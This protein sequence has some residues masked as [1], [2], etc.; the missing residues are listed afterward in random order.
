MSDQ[1]AF[2]H[3]LATLHDAML[4]DSC[5]P[6]VS[7]LID[8]ACGIKGNDL[9]V[10]EGP[11]D[12]CRVLFVGMYR[13]GQRHE[14][15]EREYLE[16]YHSIDE[17]VPRFRQ[18]P[19]GLLVPA[20]DLFTAEELKTSPTYNEA[21]PRGGCQHAL[22]VRLE[23]LDGSHI[24][25][26]L[27]DPVDSH[28]WRSSRIAMVTAFL[29]HVRQFV[30]VRQALVG[31]EARNTTVTAL[32]DNP[33]IGVVQL[34]R[35]GR[36]MAVNDRAG[37]ILRRGDGLADRNGMLRARAADEQVRLERLVGDALPAPG[38]V[39]VSGSMLVRRSAVLPPFVVHVKPV[40]VPQPDYG[41]RHVAALVLI[42]EP[43]HHQRVDP[44]LV[45]TTLGLTPGESQVAVWL[46]EG[47][48]VRDMAEA[49]GHTEGAI[50]WHLKE[51]YRKQSISRQ[52]DLVRLVL[53]LAEFGDRS[54][55]RR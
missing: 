18:Q 30:R 54:D 42:I 38:A 27:C 29:P 55:P 50:Y 46:A 15:M 11:K 31:A 28:G 26:N 10:G 25:W 20:R 21:L 3:I 53:S 6:A 2:E 48:S 8:E 33:R 44:G 45:A 14:E 16:N 34:D 51:I 9:L 23:G 13:R 37:G 22:N 35:R 41:A 36:I 19:Y 7:A 40:G 1:D 32:L 12:D 5:W 47:K 39:A 49:M 4:D 43:A 17:R 24:A 52:V